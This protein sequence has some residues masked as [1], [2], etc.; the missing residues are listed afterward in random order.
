[1]I[2]VSNLS[3]LISLLWFPIGC[4][5]LSF[6][7]LTY[8]QTKRRKIRRTAACSRIPS[9][10]NNHDEN[11]FAEVYHP[12]LQQQEEKDYDHDEE[13]HSFMKIPT[14]SSIPIIACSST[15]EVIRAISMYIQPND[16]IF[17]LGSHLSQVSR[18]M[19]E[20][21][22]PYGKAILVDVQRSDAKSGRTMNRNVHDF[23]PIYDFHS[24]EDQNTCTQE[25]THVPKFSWASFTQLQTFHQWRSALY[26]P[27]GQSP[28][29][30][31]AMILDVAASIGNDLYMT[32][33]TTAEEFMYQQQQAMIRLKQHEQHRPIRVIII[34]SRHLS[35]LA[36]R[37]IHSQRLFDATVQLPNTLVRTHEPYIIAS[38]GVEEYRRTIPF[39][40][41]PGDSCIEVGCHF[42]RT[43]VA[44]YNATV[45]ANS[46]NKKGFCIGVDIGPKII[47]HA[48][49]ELP[50]IPFAVADAW[51]VMDL[52]RLKSRYMGN[53]NTTPAEATEWGYDVIYADLGG[54]SGPDGL[55][56]SLALIDSL[57]RGIEPRTIVIKSV[58][59]NRLASR[60]KALTN[61][62]Q[63]R[64]ISFSKI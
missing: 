12:T 18:H 52:L 24:H 45:V 44:L 57:A 37:L 41:R 64:K 7:T 1:M 10:L 63:K 21:I 2:H 53:N 40:V 19:C 4:P 47:Q 39:V 38:V 23:V 17:E 46:N 62:W 30:F 61:E 3:Y 6:Q 13:R 49:K 31:D 51:R 58:C 54:L 48:T 8:I 55:I 11:N 56:E 9:L 50:H 43:T 5:C 42:G 16:T 35:S 26:E 34:K 60:L 28:I 32:A 36:R 25:A 20:T 15:I 29:R 14:S 27:R 33:L 59:L 22:G